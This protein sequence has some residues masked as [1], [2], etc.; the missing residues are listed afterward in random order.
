MKLKQLIQKIKSF[1]TGMKL[2]ELKDVKTSAEDLGKKLKN[3]I[4]VKKDNKEDKKQEDKKEEKQEE[5]KD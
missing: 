3:V 5:K 2:D 1:V 4:D